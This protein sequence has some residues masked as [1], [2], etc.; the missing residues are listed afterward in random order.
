M[1]TQA[2]LTFIAENFTNWLEETTETYDISVDE[3]Q[4]IIHDFLN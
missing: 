3:L 4:E 1:I 2:D